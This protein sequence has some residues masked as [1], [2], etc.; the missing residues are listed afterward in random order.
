MKNIALF[1]SAGMSTSMLVSKM[2]KYAECE[3]IEV[4]IEAYPEAEM[5]KRIDG[6]DVALI[7]PQIAYILPKVKKI[8]NEKGIPVEVI[9]SVDYGMMNGEKVL[10]FAMQL[11]ES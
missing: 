8:C 4:A 9:P 7:G 11:M 3:G 2:R 1:C 6:I 5:S 10:K